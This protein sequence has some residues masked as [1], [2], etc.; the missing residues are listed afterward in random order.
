MPKPSSCFFVMAKVF[1]KAVLHLCQECIAT[2]SMWI[3]GSLCGKGEAAAK[4]SDLVMIKATRYRPFLLILSK[5]VAAVAKKYEA[6]VC[7]NPRVTPETVNSRK[8][9]QLSR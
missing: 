1:P 7:Q 3:V 4:P 5:A 6:R 8:T 9:G 2:C